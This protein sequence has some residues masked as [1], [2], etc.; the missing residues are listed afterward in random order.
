LPLAERG[1]L[2]EQVTAVSRAAD[3][4]LVDLGSVYAPGHSVADVDEAVGEILD[5]I[6]DDPEDEAPTLIAAS[7]ADA[8]TDDSRMQF[9]AVRGPVSG[10]TEDGAASGGTGSAQLLT[11]SST[12][13]PG[14]LQV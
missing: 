9:A 3:I 12:R 2:G 11:S 7:I 4:V 13:Q 8:R 14:L 6:G 1:E 10:T 5:A